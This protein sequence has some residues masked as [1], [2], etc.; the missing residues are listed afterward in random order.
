MIT[1]K[2]SAS[3]RHEQYR[4]HD[5]WHT[6]DAEDRGDRFADGFENLELLEEHWLPRGAVLREKPHRDAEIVTY[7]REGA[8][9]QEDSTGWSGVINAGEFQRVSTTGRG[10]RRERNA[11]QSD[12]A[13]IFQAWLRPLTPGMEHEPEQKRFSRAD[14]RGVLCV[15]ASPDRR[16]GSL[17]V[18]QDVAVYSS[19]LDPGQHQVHALAVGRSA[20]IH[21]VRGEATLGD[22]VIAAGDGVGVSG[23]PVVSL[24]AR[25][26]TEILLI[27]LR[28]RLASERA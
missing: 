19:M 12:W 6:F 24:T 1:L 8:L 14:R 27:D 15:V 5:V 7:V 23:E 22:L 13:H 25:E 20:W 17:C 28:T 26:A 10:H 11:S 16:K 3:R 4:K 18:H 21:V 2:R 9:A